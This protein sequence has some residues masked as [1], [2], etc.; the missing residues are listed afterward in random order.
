[1][2]HMRLMNDDDCLSDFD[3]EFAIDGNWINDQNVAKDA[4]VLDDAGFSSNDETI[5]I[6]PELLADTSGQIMIYALLNW[7]IILKW[8]HIS[9]G[10]MISMGWCKEM[11]LIISTTLDMC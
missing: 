6:D 4:K 9:E 2:L 7:R 10:L 11:Y 5:N 8:V 1:M 3:K